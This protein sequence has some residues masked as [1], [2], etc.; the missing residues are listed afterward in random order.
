MKKPGVTGITRRDFCKVGMVSLAAAGFN[1]LFY[2]GCSNSQKNSSFSKTS[3]NVIIFLVDKLRPDHLG[4]YGYHKKT[5][6][7]IDRLARQAIVFDNA[8]SPC[9]WTYPSVVSLLTGLVP[10]SH[11]ATM[12]KKK[13][14]VT[15]PETWLPL[16]F[17]K[18]GY[19]TVC[20]HTHP[21]LRKNVSNIHSG[22][23]EYYDP[24]EI[25]KGN[26]RFSEHMYL[27]T[28][29]PACKRWLEENYLKSF[30]MYIHVI[31]VHGPYSK[32]H[33]LAED[34]EQ[35][36]KLLKDNYNFPRLENGMLVSSSSTP[37]P[38]KSLL[39]DGHIFD[40]D[41][42][43]SRLFNKLKELG[44]DKKTLLIF[45]SDHGEGFG[46]HNCWNHG[47]NVYENQI[48]IPLIFFSPESVGLKPGK[49]STLVN[50]VSL[51]P[52]LLDIQ[53][54]NIDKQRD[55]KSFLPILSDGRIR[56]KYNSL[57]DACLGRKEKDPDA[58]MID[59]HFKLVTDK[60][61][62]THSLFDLFEDPD[63]VHPIKLS[64]NASPRTKKIFFSL[65]QKRKKFLH[66]INRKNGVV[67]KIKKGDLEDIKTLGY[68]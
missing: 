49:I 31:D 11:G 27:D 26:S 44:I 20:F 36:N 3:S 57:S 50:T 59:N 62:K 52:T 54:A 38:H 2:P 7:N 30:F 64:K 39:Y 67:N 40:I 23:E 17:K 34:K 43:F 47:R 66:S 18:N 14:V 8:Y 37:Y 33:V 65:I 29:Y 41:M 60:K 21:F 48:R 61:N 58:F 53:G 46:E 9:P 24:S 42:Y 19:T 15:N 6:P 10:H 13:M 68:L 45:T 51:I 28:L 32:M 12:V 55:G 5:S 25:K 16:V 4:I 1:S 35:L 63:E 22:F 56:W